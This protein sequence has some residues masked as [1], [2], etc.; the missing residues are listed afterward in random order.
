MQ[1]INNNLVR[2]ELVEAVILSVLL[3]VLAWML[4]RKKESVDEEQCEAS[5]LRAE[6]LKNPKNPQKAAMLLVILVALMTCIL[7]HLIMQSLWHMPRGL[8]ISGSGLVFCWRAADWQ[9]AGF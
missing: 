7:Q 2:Q 3:T 4:S 9:Q 1:F 8:W 6:E 5:R